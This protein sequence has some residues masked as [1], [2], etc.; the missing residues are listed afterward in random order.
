MKTQH[1]QELR[2][3]FPLAAGVLIN[4]TIGILY[5]WSL[6]VAPLEETLQ[7]TRA[8]VSAAQSL[9]LMLATVGTFVMH[10]L[11]HR[12]SLARLALTMAAV[13]AAGLALAGIG[14]SV[15]TLLVGYGILFG[16]G[17]GVLYFVAMTAASIDA[18][19]RRSVAISINMSAIAIGGIIWAP[20][21]SILI[22]DL[23]PH[24]TL[25][26]EAAVLL[27]T[28]IVAFA[29]LSAAKAATAAEAGAT[30]LFQD[31]L[32]ERPRVVIAIFLGF[33]CIAFT[34]LTSIGHAATMIG[35]WGASASQTQ[36]APILM[37][38]GYII[39]ALVAGPLVDLLSGRRVLI[40]VGILIGCLLLALYS[41]PG[42]ALGLAALTIVGG[43]FG[44]LASGQPVTLA[45]YYG[46]AALPRIYG[47]VAIA[48]GLG[49]L[50]GPFAAGAIYDAEL[51]YDTVIILIAIIALLG[52][53]SYAGLPRQEARRREAEPAEG[54]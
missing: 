36:F 29:L 10:R 7:A 35:S 41:A 19:I 51:R 1:T 14:H 44:A 27:T 18:P 33:L 13:A 20:I 42:V 28:G 22:D 37:S 30:G 32:T 8:T 5:T 25:G 6:F 12:L 9:G 52:A 54:A 4:L 3:Y 49:G 53:V 23:G 26:V 15:A 43:C 39:G 16:F 21:L 47:R 45:N 50:L 34:A 24:L 40:G 17:A 38:A 2:A 48:Y 31:I 11:L 46:A